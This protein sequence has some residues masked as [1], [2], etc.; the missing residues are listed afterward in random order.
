MNNFTLLPVSRYYNTPS[1]PLGNVKLSEN[2]Y[3]FSNNYFVQLIKFSFLTIQRRCFKI[4]SRF[5]QIMPAAV[6]IS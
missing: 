4:R 6:H 3:M 2:L 1:S 5:N